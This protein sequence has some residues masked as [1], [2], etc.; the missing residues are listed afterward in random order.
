MLDSRL[1]EATIPNVDWQFSG[2][3]SE[4]SHTRRNPPLIRRDLFGA[5]LASAAIFW[6]GSCGSEGPTSSESSTAITAPTVREPA[7]GTQ[8]T[9]TSP[10]LTVGNATGALALRYRFEV[11]SDA[12]FGTIVAVGDD[13]AEGG[14]GTTSW[15]VSPALDPGV[16]YQWRARASSNGTLGP[17]SSVASFEVAGGFH[18]NIPVGGVYISDPL[19]NGTSVGEV[20]SGTFNARGWMA[21]DAAAYIRY[22]IPSTPNGFVE[23]QVTNLRNPNP[24][25]DKRALLIM[26]DPSKGD[27][28][29]NPFRVNI[30]KY[31]TELV[32][33]GHLRLRWISQ[34]EERN[35]WTDFYDWHPEHIYTFRME[36]GAFPQ[37]TTTQRVRL[38]LDGSEI[39]VR[40]YDKI[41]RPTTHWVELGMAPREESLEQA[42]YS[43]VTIGVRQP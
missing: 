27:F 36:W 19:T 35:T 6:L 7:T 20:Y 17:Y 2:L 13:V 23:F 24:R 15:T 22:E 38:L 25:S 18:S 1:F 21:T 37:V 41:Y 40:N 11:G 30:S 32:T 42:I 33:F 31:D 8:V 14:T 16:T 10:T 34:G 39:L 3:D 26:W 4:L 43:N 28:T 5:I 12:S 9:S 29:D